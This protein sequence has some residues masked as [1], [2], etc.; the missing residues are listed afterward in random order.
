MSYEGYDGSSLQPLTLRAF[1]WINYEFILYGVLPMICQQS[2]RYCLGVEYTIH[3]LK[4]WQKN[5]M[6]S[7]RFYTL[8]STLHRDNLMFICWLWFISGGTGK[9]D[10]NLTNYHQNT[11][12]KQCMALFQAQ[13]VT[14][15]NSSM[16]CY[17]FCVELI[18]VM[19]AADQ[20]PINFCRNHS[21]LCE[22]SGDKGFKSAWYSVSGSA[23][24]NKSWLNA[25]AAVCPQHRIIFEE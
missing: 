17:S 23:V 5:V 19:V 21:S 15:Q 12:A 13:L 9:Y 6:G 11:L 22:A 4:W 20:R 14:Y 16:S 25:T 3:Y 10:L 24:I 8:I 7:T 18:V 1:C 2:F